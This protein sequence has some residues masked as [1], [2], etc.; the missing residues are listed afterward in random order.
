MKEKKKLEMWFSAYEIGYWAVMFITDGAYASFLS[1][2][3]YGEAF[4]GHTLTM[5]G[6]ASIFLMPLGGYLADRTSR[7]RLLSCIYA[8]LTAA[9]TLLVVSDPS[10]AAVYLYAIVGGV[11]CKLLAGTLDSWIGKIAREEKDLD[12]GR[13][14]SAGSIAYAVASPVLGGLFARAGYWVSAPAGALLCALVFLSALMLRDPAVRENSGTGPGIGETARYLLKNRAYRIYL[15]C[16]MLMNVTV[17]SFFAFA[18]LLMEEAGGDVGTLGIYYFIMALLEFFVVRS[19]SRISGK[20]GVKR[21]FAAGMV[22]NF[23]KS[24]A[25]SFASSVPAMYL[26]SLTQGFSF[27][28]AVPSNAVYQQKWVDKRYLSTA[29]LVSQTCCTGLVPFLLS[30]AY[31]SLAERYSVAV[32]LRL[33]SVTALAAGILFWILAPDD[34]KTKE[35]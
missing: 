30:S 15:I 29:T 6:F 34:R 33:F 13:I 7:Y 2:L 1:S 31:G 4:I 22:G 23:V 3:G 27:A 24:F 9:S 16:A 5:L 35:V 28:L 12:Y 18:G 26:C 10:P 32:M 20:L 21:T 11:C 17:Q 8:L 25:H 19:Y 14:R